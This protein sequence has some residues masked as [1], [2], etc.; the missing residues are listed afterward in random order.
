MANKFVFVISPCQL[1]CPVSWCWWE[2]QHKRIPLDWVGWMVRCSDERTKVEKGTTPLLSAAAGRTT[3]EIWIGME[4]NIL[5]E[6]EK[7]RVH[8]IVL[9]CFSSSFFPVLL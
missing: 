4:M 5:G 6:E 8:G 2:E 7:L 1:C 9:P 3:S